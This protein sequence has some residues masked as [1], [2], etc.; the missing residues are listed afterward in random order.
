MTADINQ[1]PEDKARDNI[2][3]MLAEAGWQ[4]QNKDKI[5]FNV[6]LGVAVREYQTDVGPAD[7]VLFDGAHYDIYGRHRLAAIAAAISWFKKHLVTAD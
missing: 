4:V 5:D 3:A 7:Y 1:K 2:D 6:G